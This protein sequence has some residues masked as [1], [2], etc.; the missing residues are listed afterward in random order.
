MSVACLHPINISG[1]LRPCGHCEVCRHKTIVDWITRVSCDIKAIKMKKRQSKEMN[2][3]NSNNFNDR[4]S[5]FT[6]SIFFDVTYNKQFLPEDQSLSIDDYQKFLKRFRRRYEKRYG[7]KGIRF[8]AAGEYGESEDG[9]HRPHY[10]FVMWN[11]PNL[12]LEEHTKNVQEAWKSYGFV[13]EDDK[14][15]IPVID[16]KTGDWKRGRVSMGFSK[17]EIPRGQTDAAFYVAE[18]IGYVTKNGLSKYCRCGNESLEDYR[19]RTGK[20]TFPFVRASLGLGYDYVDDCA[21][22]MIRQGYI[23]DGEYKVRIPPIY[24]S[25]LKSFVRKTFFLNK[26][27]RMS[28]FYSDVP[29][30]F[31]C[32]EVDQLADILSVQDLFFERLRNFQNRFFCGLDDM[33]SNRIEVA[34]DYIRKMRR[35]YSCVSCCDI[36]VFRHKLE[37]IL[38]YCFDR[39]CGCEL[40][41]YF[42]RLY[43]Y[44]EDY[45]NSCCMYEN[46]VYRYSDYDR[47]LGSYQ[48]SRR[49]N[50]VQAGANFLSK[51]RIQSEYREKKAAKRIAQCLGGCL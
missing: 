20:C 46:L 37:R 9:T 3:V 42:D 49:D 47:D 17:V 6:E 27:T 51:V 13:Y 29:F 23:Q 36:K 32:Y 25:R 5:F 41:P 11:L 45:L 1:K 35:R 33:V 12:T 14:C 50:V 19:R 7:W 48:L 4:K 40:F 31:N 15:T 22:Q 24:Q 21:E 39:G 34:I 38:D 8:I 44:C 18:S 10:H 26:L 30:N 16:P 2:G 43:F 28:E